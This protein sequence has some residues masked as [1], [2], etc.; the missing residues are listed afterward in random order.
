MAWTGS[1]PFVRVNDGLAGT[2]NMNITADS[3][4]VALYNN[5]ITPDRTV[6]AAN[7]CYNVGQWATA[8]EVVDGTN[9]PTAGRPGVGASFTAS[10]AVYT[11]DLNDTASNTSASTLSA[12]GA[13]TYSDTSTTPADQGICYNY[14]GGLAAVTGGLFTI[15]W[16]PSGLWAATVS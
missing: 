9:W 6:S 7:S 14:F 15:V 4:K 5:S 3:L 10:G 16:N 2:R 13:L 1:A 12:Y 8:N 11:F